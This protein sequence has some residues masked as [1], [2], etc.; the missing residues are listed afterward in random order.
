MSPASVEGGANLLDAFRE[1][2][3][4][5]SVKGGCW[6][7][8]CGT[9]TVLSTLPRVSCVTLVETSPGT[10]STPS[11][12][13]AAAPDLHP[14]QN[15]FMERFASQC[16]YCTPGM[17]MAPE[18]LLDRNPEPTRA[19]TPSTRSCG[20]IVP[21]CTGYYPDHRG[22]A[23]PPPAAMP[24]PAPEGQN[25]VMLE[26][27][28]DIFADERDDNLQEIGQPT[29]VQDILGHVTGTSA[30]YDDHRF[31]NLLHR[32]KFF[33]QPACARPHPLDSTIG[34]G[35]RSRC[36]TDHPRRRRTGQSQHAV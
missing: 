1:C 13:C 27:R 22:G 3:G 30:Y 4:D 28:K 33:P 32:R 2:V 35:A 34:G 23:R 17:L 36:Q 19:M 5:L 25:R 21:R 6:Q 7:G 11:P 8:T 18:A 14:L 12:A 16:G 24:P 10:P 9:C 29:Q 26:F 15:A 20:N 31:A